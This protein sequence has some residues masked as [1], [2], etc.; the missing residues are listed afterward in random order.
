MSRS[1][2]QRALALVAAVAAVAASVS[3][4]PSN[5]QCQSDAETVVAVG[6]KVR[7]RSDPFGGGPKILSFRK[8]YFYFW[9][10]FVSHTRDS[11]QPAHKNNP[12]WAPNL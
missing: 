8:F 2:S 3:A 1:H 10:G 6:Q 4:H 12:E 9:G 11:M 7:W 5:L